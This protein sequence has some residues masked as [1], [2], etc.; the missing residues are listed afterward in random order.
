[1]FWYYSKH[2]NQFGPVD[3]GELHRLA[4]E[5]GILPQDLVWNVTMGDQWMPASTIE[6]L[7]PRPATPPL[8]P[9]KE[10]VTPVPETRPSVF[11]QK[12]QRLFAPVV[13]A[14]RIGFKYLAGL[15][16]LLPVLKTGATMILSIAGY[17]M[18]WGWRFGVGF[19]LLILIHE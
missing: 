15:K 17:A 1:M 12:I 4:R 8:I 13:A 14:C 16:F 9:N 18:V 7:F 3:D 19:V 2:G 11:R 10:E 6:S 5:G